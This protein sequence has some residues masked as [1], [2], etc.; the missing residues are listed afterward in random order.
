MT[1]G[2]TI[3]EFV[4]LPTSGKTTLCRRTEGALGEARTARR[5]DRRRLLVRAGAVVRFRRAFTVG[6]CYVLRGRRS[7][8]HRSFAVRT[9]AATLER[10][11]APHPAGAVVLLP[12]GAVQRS[13]LCFV[14]P[15]R[16]IPSDGVARYAAAIPV[17]DVIVRLRV[18][19]E[20]AVARLQ[21]A[22]RHPRPGATRVN[23]LAGVGPAALLATFTDA[24]AMLDDVVAVVVARS[25]G[26][27]RVVDI[28]AD[29]H[30]VA[31]AQWRARLLPLLARGD[32]PDDTAGVGPGRLGA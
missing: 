8:P 10:Y 26:R 24:A 3:V 30:A 13:F 15:G 5:P 12:E 11:A 22:F 19:P 29:E 31:E 28:D 16:P 18:R 2:P 4:G 25:G 9:L 32:A 1:G 14:E 23:R 21:R 17:P 20:V 6:A 7:W 27:T